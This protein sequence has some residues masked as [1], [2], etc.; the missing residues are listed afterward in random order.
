VDKLAEV[1]EEKSRFLE[2]SAIQEAPSLKQLKELS[3]MSRSSA[4]VLETF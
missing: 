1:E 4:K 2:K 3:E